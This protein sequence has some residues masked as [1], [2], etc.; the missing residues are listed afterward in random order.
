MSF[1]SLIYHIEHN[2]S[3]AKS[4]KTGNPQG[5]VLG[6]LFFNIFINELVD[7]GEC[8]KVLFADDS[9]FCLFYDTFQQC[10]WNFETLIKKIYLW[11]S[12]NAIIANTKKTKLVLITNRKV[13]SPPLMVILWSGLTD[14][15]IYDSI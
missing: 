3:D 9:V 1:L 10:I 7:I 14:L 2:I 13:N 11:L 6:P 12:N 4:I 8:D 5:S 15:N